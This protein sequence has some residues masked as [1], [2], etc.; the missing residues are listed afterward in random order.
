MNTKTLKQ[1]S[2]RNSD[3]VWWSGLLQPD[4]GAS[5]E[6]ILGYLGLPKTVWHSHLISSV[7]PVLLML[8]FA[9]IK[10]VPSALMVGSNCF[11]PRRWWTTDLSLS[12]PAALGAAGAVRAALSG[13]PTGLVAQRHSG[14]AAKGPCDIPYQRISTTV[15]ILGVGALGAE[16]GPEAFYSLATSDPFSSIAY[17]RQYPRSA[18]CVDCALARCTV[19]ESQVE[20]HRSFATH[21]GIVDDHPFQLHDRK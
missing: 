8:L 1:F 19:P 11:L 10:D 16:D 17:G 13:R 5:L 18:F 12:S 9:V 14:G 4:A 20:C 21:H 3:I 2:S 15:C 6:C 7:T